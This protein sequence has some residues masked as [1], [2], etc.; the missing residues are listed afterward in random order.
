MRKLEIEVTEMLKIVLSIY[1]YQQFDYT[2]TDRTETE[3]KHFCILNTKNIFI[4]L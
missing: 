4:K 2:I 1:R 3:N